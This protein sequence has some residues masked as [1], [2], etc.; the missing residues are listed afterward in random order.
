MVLLSVV[1]LLI[2]VTGKSRKGTYD[3]NYKHYS[4]IMH[5][6][7]NRGK[8]GF[9]TTLLLPPPQRMLEALDERAAYSQ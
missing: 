8:L 5:W 4:Q 6:S 1:K 7:E 3:A 9:F 2:S